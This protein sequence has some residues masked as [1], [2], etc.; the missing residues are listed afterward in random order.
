MSIRSRVRTEACADVG[1]PLLEPGAPALEDAQPDLA[2]SVRAKKAKRT[3]KLV[4]VPGGRA[5][6]A[7]R[8]WKCSL[9]SAVSS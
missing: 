9:P 7:T 4:V 1:Q 6:A 5:G 2:A 8:S 3:S